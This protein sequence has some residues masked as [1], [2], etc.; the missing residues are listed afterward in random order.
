[1]ACVVCAAQKAER[2]CGECMG[3]LEEIWRLEDVAC[4]CASCGL[5]PL[6]QEVFEE[7]FPET[8]SKRDPNTVL[9]V[10]HRPGSCHRCGPRI[11]ESH[12]VIW[13]FPKR[14]PS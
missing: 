8:A 9:L 10:I 11:P 1:M 6:E 4:S 12:A 5:S 13:Q 14:V 2:L 7:M 3:R